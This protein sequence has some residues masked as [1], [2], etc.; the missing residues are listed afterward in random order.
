M[1]YRALEALVWCVCLIPGV[2]YALE[3]DHS[4]SRELL[5][6][7]NCKTCVRLNPHPRQDP[8]TGLKPNHDGD[9]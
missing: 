1:I 2:R 7:C 5:G 9:A 3:L 4:P 6:T 8:W